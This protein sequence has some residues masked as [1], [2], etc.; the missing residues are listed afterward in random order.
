MEDALA[1]IHCWLIANQKRCNHEEHEE[2]ARQR[3]SIVLMQ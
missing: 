3:K 2:E 1:F